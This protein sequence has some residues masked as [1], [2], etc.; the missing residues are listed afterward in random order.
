MS[1]AAPTDCPDVS[2]II[3]TRDRRGRLAI[4]LRSALA[5]RDVAVEILVVDDGSQDGTTAM[6]EGLGE[7]RIRVLRNE[8][9]LGESGARNRGIAAARGAWVAF[10]DDDDLWAPDKLRLQL[11]AMS[12]AAREWAY[13][14]EVTVDD[15]LRV[16]DGA[17]PPSPEAVLSSLVRHNSVPAGASNVI[18]GASLLS[19]AGRFDPG[20]RRTADW[21]MW[22]RL[23]R[24]GPPACVPRPLVAIRTHP[25]NVSRDMQSM[26]LELD[27]MAR[28]HKVPVDRARHYRWAAWNARLDGRR[29]QAL[30]CYAGAIA[31]GDVRSM[32]RAAVALARRFPSPA[33]APDD[34]W[35]DEARAWI[36][37]LAPPVEVSA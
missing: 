8:T 18:V 33:R 30:R 16:V 7:G 29:W 15:D 27:I 4:A 2:V 1:A 26:F 3:P 12:G 28:R 6:V 5:Q 23:A 10:L 34:A 20:L 22:L 21:D 13:A 11:S 31:A 35:T 25:G 17:P 19:R 24:D 32:G 36:E 9:P 37:T 14:G